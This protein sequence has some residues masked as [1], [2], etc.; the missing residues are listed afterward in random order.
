MKVEN[1]NSVQEVSGKKKH[2]LAAATSSGETEF[3]TFLRSALGKSG[4]QGTNEEALFSGL[5]QE[6][7]NK[8]GSAEAQAKFEKRITQHR[9]ILAKHGS[10]V[11]EE[12]AAKFALRD[13]VRNE[14]MSK[15][16]AAKIYSIAFAS[17]QLDGDAQ[18]LADDVV[19]TGDDVNT[20]LAQLEQTVT[21]YADGSKEVPLRKLSEGTTK[22]S[23]GGLGIAGLDASGAGGSVPR[24]FLFKPVSDTQGSLV[25]LLPSSMNSKVD[26]VVLK[27]S[28][29]KVIES[30]KFSG[31]GNGDRQHYRYTRP[32]SEYPSNLVVEVRLKGGGVETITIPDPALRYE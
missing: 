13:L 19:S 20:R 17:A 10:Y 21:A 1:T 24:G 30:G 2:K 29:G 4:S 32:G 25:I 9:K 12:R 22:G 5:V 3:S 26:E 6:R 14:L 23:V 18:T 16:E 27:D 28:S 7:V 15:E 31:I 8:T 11:S